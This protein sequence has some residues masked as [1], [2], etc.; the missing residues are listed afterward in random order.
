MASL[1]DD[2][3]SHCALHR[4]GGIASARH[5][6]AVSPWI[7]VACDACWCDCGGAVDSRVHAG[8]V[9]DLEEE[10]AAWWGSISGS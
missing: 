3:A 7:V 5:P 9:R 8:A 2:L 4:H 10:E 1:D 6:C